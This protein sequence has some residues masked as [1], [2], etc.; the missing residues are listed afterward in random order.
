MQRLLEK[1]F[2]ASFVLICSVICELLEVGGRVSH[3]W[4]GPRV[5][6]ALPGLFRQFLQ[7]PR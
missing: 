3:A 1:S 7:S 5:V 2:G 6:C 4:L